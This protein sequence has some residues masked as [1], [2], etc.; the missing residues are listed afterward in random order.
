MLSHPSLC[1]DLGRF[2]RQGSAPGSGAG[3][4]VGVGGGVAGETPNSLWRQLSH[5]RV[6]QDKEQ[7]KNKRTF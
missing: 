3:L 6:P 4:G 5:G 1:T 7:K 2:E